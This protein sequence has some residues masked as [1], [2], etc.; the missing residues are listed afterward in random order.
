MP[1]HATPGGHSEAAPYFG[2][3]LYELPPCFGQRL[4]IS[5]RDYQ[6]GLPTINAESP[7]SVTT[8]GVS[9][10]MASPTAMGK[11]SL[12]EAVVAMSIPAK[13]RDIISTYS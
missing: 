5:G 12:R 2:S 4:R 13:R 3:G 1:L 8:Q 9:Q 7:T 11:A 10:A 6:T